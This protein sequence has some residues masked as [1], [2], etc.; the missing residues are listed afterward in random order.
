L[1]TSDLWEGNAGG[2]SLDVVLMDLEMPVM[3]GL[4]C[5]RRIR[6]LQSQGTLTRHVPIIAVTANARKEQ[7]EISMAAGMVSHDPFCNPDHTC[8][9]HDP[10]KSTSLIRY[11]DDVMPKPFRVAELLPRMENLKDPKSEVPSGRIVPALENQ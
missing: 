1:K 8:G 7:I 4:T 9:F 10:S 3:D 2:Q 6:E 5:A 11:K